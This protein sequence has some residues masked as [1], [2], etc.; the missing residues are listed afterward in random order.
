MLKY[1]SAAAT[2]KFFSL[3]AQTKW[4]YRKLGNLI[5]QRRKIKNGLEDWRMIN[6]RDM[7]AEIE[8][9]YLGEESK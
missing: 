1:I 5:G 2:F 7:L 6:A 3:T 4:A 9:G 8:K